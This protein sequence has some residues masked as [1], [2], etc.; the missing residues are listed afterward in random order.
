MSERS[1]TIWTSLT[2]HAILTAGG[3]AH[4]HA[5]N[6]KFYYSNDVYEMAEM[7]EGYQNA[8]ESRKRG[9]KK[10]LDDFQAARMELVESIVKV[11]LF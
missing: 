3:W 10:A 1:A 9:A 6:S 5:S 11:G 4:G 8:V 7:L 2:R